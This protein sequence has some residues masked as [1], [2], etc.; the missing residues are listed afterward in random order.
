MDGE[1]MQLEERSDHQLDVLVKDLDYRRKKQWDIFSWSS[2][3]LISI[4]GAVCLLASQGKLTTL[5][6]WEKAAISFSAV[7]IAVFAQTWIH[8]HWLYELDLSRI[9]GASIGFSIFRKKTLIGYPHVLTALTLASL[10]AIW[11]P[12]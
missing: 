6:A 10:W 3:I 9:V 11:C 2:A 1:A 12:V 5:P 8:Y 4:T 7:V